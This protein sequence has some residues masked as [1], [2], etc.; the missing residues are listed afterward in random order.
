M[1]AAQKTVR[2]L[3]V[4]SSDPHPEW[5]DPDHP[6]N[7][8]C[9]RDEADVAPSGRRAEPRSAWFSRKAAEL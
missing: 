6:L 9:D 1:S 5:H 2:D 3:L 8:Q 7:R 4:W